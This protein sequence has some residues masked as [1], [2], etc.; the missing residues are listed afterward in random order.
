MVVFSL[1]IMYLVF[2]L[3]KVGTFLS[4]EDVIH[5][6]DA[7]IV[8]SGGGNERIR[9]GVSLYKS[10]MSNTLIVTGATK[11][12]SIS[13]AQSMA[14]YAERRGV[15]MDNILKEPKAGNTFENAKL[16]RE[17]FEE[18]PESIILVTTEYHQKRAFETFKEHYPNTKIYNSP[19]KVAFWN[20]DK[21]WGNSKSI[22]LGLSEYIKILWG[23]MTGIWG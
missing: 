8:V 22:Y 11:D 1:L 7:I 19:A 17:F 21:W 10:K 16:T 23:Q 14:I 15:P 13:N 6:S 5:P 20:T 3:E 4:I 12:G 9:K 2:S 18:D